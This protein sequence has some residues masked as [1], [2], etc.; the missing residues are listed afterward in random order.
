MVLVHS[1]ADYGCMLEVKDVKTFPDGRSV[2]DT[3]GVS[4]FRVLSHGQR[5]GYSTAKIELLEDKKVCV[6][7]V[8]VRC[9]GS[10]KDC[11]R[12]ELPNR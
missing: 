3:V 11:I 12:D 5:D 2:V 9:G 7:W 6:L 10:F 4:R 8:C 1:F